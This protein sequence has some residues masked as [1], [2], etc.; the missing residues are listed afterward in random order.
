M[1]S[2]LNFLGEEIRSRR[3]ALKL[4]HNDACLVLCDHATQ[5]SSKKFV[6]LKEDFM[7]K[8]NAVPRRQMV[9]FLY[10]NTRQDTHDVNLE[11]VYVLPH[12]STNP[13][14]SLINLGHHHRG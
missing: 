9:M 12:P 6:Y 11:C 1:I 10:E 7:K 8:H 13:Q 14:H 3:R 4:S 5:H 2:Y